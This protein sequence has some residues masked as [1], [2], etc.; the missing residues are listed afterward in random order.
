M[1][2][3]EELRPLTLDEAS[4]LLGTTEKVV[5]SAFKRGEL[6]GFKIGRY[7]RIL[8]ESVQ[9]KLAGSNEQ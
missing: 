7:Y 1:S 5:R 4:V 3:Q 9:Q 2:Y 8:P 6:K